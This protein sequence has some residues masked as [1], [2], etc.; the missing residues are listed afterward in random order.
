MR[1][2]E[3]ETYKKNSQQVVEQLVADNMGHVVVMA[4]KYMGH[5]LAL[6]DLVNE[7]VIGMIEAAAKFDMGRGHKFVAYATPFIRKNMERAVEEQTSLYRVPKKEMTRLRAQQRKALSVDAPLAGGRQM[8]LLDILIDSNSPQP[9]EE[10]LK[11]HIVAE[12]TDMLEIL[13]EREQHVVT[14]FYGL[15]T[16]RRSLAEIGGELNIKRERAR[17]IRDT[18]IRKMSRH[19]H[20]KILRGFLKA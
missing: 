6:D 3:E 8:T 5:G 10:V 2:M 12:L 16:A 14:A 4:K 9:D 15:G 19:T 1:P 11:N 13:T 17:Q 20:N 7:G 18:A